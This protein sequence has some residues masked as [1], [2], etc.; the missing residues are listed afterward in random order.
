MFVYRSKKIINNKKLNIDMSS[1]S[2]ILPYLEK[3]WVENIYCVDQCDI[4]NL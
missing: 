3:L 4:Y 1:M 2:S